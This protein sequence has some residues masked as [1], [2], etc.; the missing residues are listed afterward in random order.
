M[1]TG[2]LAYVLVFA[3]AVLFVT[4]VFLSEYSKRRARDR[5]RHLR[6]LERIA[7]NVAESRQDQ[8]GRNA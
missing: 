2:S 7:Q 5:E 8:P 4:I 1:D 3:G 6:S